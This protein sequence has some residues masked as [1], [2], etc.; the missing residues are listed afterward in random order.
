[1]NETSAQLNTVVSE[2]KNK[3]AELSTLRKQLATSTKEL[4]NWKQK[5]K[6]SS[7]AEDKIKELEKEIKRRLLEIKEL[8]QKNQRLE[9]KNSDLL[10]VKVG[11]ETKLNQ[12]HEH[13]DFLQS[14]IAS[15]QHQV[16]EFTHDHLNQEEHNLAK[17]ESLIKD[18]KDE[19]VRLKE[20]D[21]HL[22]K[23][24]KS[25]NE[26]QAQLAAAYDKKKE[27]H[28]Q[29]SRKLQQQPSNNM[30]M[31]KISYEELISGI[32]DIVRD[33]ML[34]S[35]FGNNLQ[36]HIARVRGLIFPPALFGETA[37]SEFVDAEKVQLQLENARLQE[38]LGHFKRVTA[39]MEHEFLHIKEKLLNTIAERSSAEGEVGQYSS[40]H[41]SPTKVDFSQQTD[42]K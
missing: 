5:A 28:L 35:N 4:T 33:V 27:E 39:E 37:S 22:S 15:L 10:A 17:Y 2:L 20:R 14:T 40:P 3:E 25:A 24:L 13:A 23:Q 16:Q 9:N 31:T 1:V 7:E 41:K 36:D 6:I 42:F 26:Q 38:E 19:I 34:S 8:S 18:L 29:L 32:S 11:L 21:K 12:A 30:S